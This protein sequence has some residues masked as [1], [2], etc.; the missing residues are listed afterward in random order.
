MNTLQEVWQ[1]RKEKYSKASDLD[2]KAAVCLDKMKRFLEI[3]NTI[4]KNDDSS[5][6]S[7]IKTSVFNQ[8]SAKLFEQSAKSEFY[9]CKANYLRHDADIMFF[10]SVMDKHGNANVCFNSY[11]TECDILGEKFI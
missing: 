8:Y 9:R 6:T 2:K 1:F 7:I 3:R 10:L 4:S 11:K 5:I